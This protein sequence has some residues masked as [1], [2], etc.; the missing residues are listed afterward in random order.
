MPQ[1]LNLADVEEAAVTAASAWLALVDGG[2][3]AG[4]WQSA[5]AISRNA[6]AQDQWAAQIAAAR[7]PLGKAVSRNLKSKALMTELP[8]APEGHYVVLQFETDFADAAGKIE[9]VTPML[10]PDGQWR[11][12]GYYIQ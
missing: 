7:A 11:V 9:T 8:N 10:D 6:V 1:P 3:H 2:N 4:S 12:S 5:A